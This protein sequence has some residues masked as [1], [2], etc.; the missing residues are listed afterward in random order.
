MFAIVTI[1]KIFFSSS[2]VI[3][4]Y[5][6]AIY[7]TNLPLAFLLINTSNSF[8]PK[9]IFDIATILAFCK[10][11]LSYLWL[12]LNKTKEAK[13]AFFLGNYVSIELFDICR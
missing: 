7:W 11:F 6:N 10:Y 2:L 12:W 8:I 9:K 5:F 4:F 13:S 1:L 3:F